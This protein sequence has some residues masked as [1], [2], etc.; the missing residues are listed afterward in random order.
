MELT[1][2]I[3]HACNLRC[4]YCY[5]GRKSFRHMPK[6]IGEKA[7]A[8]AFNRLKP[9]DKIQVGYFGGEPLLAWDLVQHFH[10][11]AKKLAAEKNVALKGT[12]TT[13]A[14]LLTEQQMD[15]MAANGVYVGISIDGIETA[16]D[17]TRRYASGDSTF[18]AA[19]RGLKIALARAP[20]TQTV[21]VVDPGNV[22]Y[23]AESTRFLLDEGVRVMSLSLNYGGAWDDAILACYA[24][25]IEQ[26][27]DEF[28]R[29]FRA[30]Q[31]IYIACLDSKII[32]HLKKGLKDCDK[33]SFGVGE[34]AVAPSG[35]LYPCE[36]LVGD[37]HD[38]RFQIG[39][40][41]TGVD[42]PKLA[43]I[44]RRRLQPDPTCQKCALR[45]RCMNFCGC[46]NVF[47]SG[48]YAVAGPTIC[49]TEQL[50]ARVADRVAKTLFWE[51]NPILLRKYYFE[52]TVVS[53]Q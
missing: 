28:I 39:S 24:N 30:G 11:H 48:D 7:L 31:D 47:S 25:Q 19:R 45:E 22:Q 35:R 29:R 32:G 26:V 5:A 36:R 43:E 27:G 10:L 44:N 3:T 42:E 20:L 34:I 1:L 13:N 9:G 2:V 41:Q 21:S 51:G 37:D 49:L 14:T 4:V 8:W 15:W 23:V 53:G 50:Y 38:P 16:H 33:C 6:E 52:N 46:S 12:V 40:I 17:A 18:A